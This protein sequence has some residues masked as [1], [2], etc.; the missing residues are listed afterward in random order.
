MALQISDI[1]VR[2]IVII[3]CSLHEPWTLR[4]TVHISKADVS[5]NDCLF[6]VCHFSTHK[7]FFEASADQTVME[8]IFTE[9]K[10]KNV[11]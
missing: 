7:Y 10:R 1:P 6:L 2:F 9:I 4:G 5:L 8:K 11:T 3:S